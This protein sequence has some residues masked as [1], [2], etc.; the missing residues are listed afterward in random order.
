MALD[1]ELLSLLYLGPAK[2]HP[3]AVAELA[4]LC[5]KRHDSTVRF[6]FTEGRAAVAEIDD[7]YTEAVRLGFVGTAIMWRRYAIGARERA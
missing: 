6:N 4:L 2:T 7:Y 1:M 3:S 5:C